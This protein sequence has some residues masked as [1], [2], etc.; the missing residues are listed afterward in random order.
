MCGIA[1]IYRFGDHAPSGPQR[2]TDRRL[3]ATMGQA[4]EYRGP[5]DHGLES[6]GRATLGVRR[7]SILDVSG[8][9]QPL[10]DVS[11]RVWAIQN[12]EIYNFPALRAEL[13]GRHPLRTHT[14]TE[15]LPYLWLEGRE[16]G[17]ERLDGMFACA[18][19]DAAADTLLLARDPLGVKPLYVARSADR[20]LF[21]SELKAILCD[22]DV[23]RELDPDA[24]GAYLAL[25]F[26][27]GEATPF[28]AVRKVR[29]GCRVLATPDGLRTERYWGWPRFFDAPSGGT[30]EALA[31]E[32][33]ER[34]GAATR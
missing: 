29:P 18:I 27:P 20:L 2:E 24:I 14:D 3:V 34:L 21:A 1:G 9:H 28:R 12:G 4:I 26:I 16:R 6:L 19:F 15:L 8:G 33:G 10:A 13:A 17:I 5:D 32:V 31:D 11:G 22:P 23:P 30:M 25:G 7:L